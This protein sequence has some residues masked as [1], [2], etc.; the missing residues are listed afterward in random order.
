MY[1]S[2][3]TDKITSN[4]LDFLKDNFIY[5][6]TFKNY[7]LTCDGP[8][9]RVEFFVILYT[10]IPGIHFGSLVPDSELKCLNMNILL[11]Y[12][13]EN[14]DLIEVLDNI[15]LYR[16]YEQKTYIEND[17]QSYAQKYHQENQ[18]CMVKLIQKLPTVLVENQLQNNCIL[19]FLFQENFVYCPWRSFYFVKILAK[20]NLDLNI[21]P[22]SILGKTF[23]NEK[24]LEN[25]ERIISC[26]KLVYFLIE[27][28]YNFKHLNINTHLNLYLKKMILNHQIKESCFRCDNLLGIIKLNESLEQEGL[29]DIFL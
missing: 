2:E 18:K 26:T 5:F 17:E 22:L 1:L 8:E 12:M 10:I 7:Y 28:N 13:T 11:T 24:K 25:W 3:Y 15:N 29:I 27:N 4:D 19:S 9:T 23:I 14:L 21:L 16:L 20:A 6:N